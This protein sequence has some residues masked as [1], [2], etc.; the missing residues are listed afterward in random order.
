MTTQKPQR[1]PWARVRIHRAAGFPD[2]EAMHC[3]ESEGTTRL[4]HEGHNLTLITHG[5][6][7]ARYRGRVLELHAGVL[8]VLEPGE[9]YASFRQHGVGAGKGL[10]LAGTYMIDAARERGIA[11]TLRLRAATF[12]NPALTANLSFLHDLWSAPAATRLERE[13]AL[14][15]VVGGFLR[16]QSEAAPPAIPSGAHAKVARAREYL[17]AHLE[18]EI[19]LVDLARVAGCDRFYL[20]RAFRRQFGLPPHA[21]QLALRVARARALLARGLGPTECAYDVGFCDVSHLNRHMVRMLGAPAGVF[22]AAP[23]RRGRVVSRTH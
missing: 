6:T 14:L 8:A 7:E 11:G 17:Q 20:T 21:Y 1:R 15:V 13:E 23:R 16:H 18:R 3:D 9:T 10:H 22:A 19:S 12:A 2:V 5:R 4:V